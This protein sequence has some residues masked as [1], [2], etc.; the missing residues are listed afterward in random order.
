MKSSSFTDPRDSRTYTSVRLGKQIWMAENLASSHYRNGDQV[1][2]IRSNTRW[3]NADGACCYFD[4]T[5]AYE[6][7]FGKLYN[8]HAVTDP[9]ELA[10]EGWHIPSDEEWKE[11]EMFLGLSRVQA[12]YSGWRGE[13]EGG[14]LKASGK[15]YWHAPNQ[16]A[17]D[18]YGFAGLP[19]GYRDVSGD[20][21]VKGYA[22]YWWTSTMEK[23]YF[24]W[25]RTLYHSATKI[26]RKV[27]YS[28][29]GFSVRCIKDN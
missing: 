7:T 23:E 20:F 14:L 29:D 15:E 22:G 26:H 5:S 21:Y 3:G 17:K 2:L 12:D 18:K 19:G 4:K 28:G 25:Y 10:P 16:D 9:R 27:G 11:L 13:K 8:W 24:A 6:A 1:E